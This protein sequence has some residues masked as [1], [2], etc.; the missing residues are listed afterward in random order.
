MP[1]IFVNYRTGDG[2]W[3]ASR[4]D[5]ALSD[6]FGSHEVFLAP[7]SIP[8]GSDFE[9]DI[10]SAV[11]S[12][13]VLLVVVGA[14]WLRKDTNGQRGLDDPADW[15]RREIAEAIK[16]RLIVVPILIDRTERLTHASLPPDIAA[17]TTAQFIRLDHRT[18]HRDL[19]DLATK[20]VKLAPGLA[21]PTDPP[22]PPVASGP[23]PDQP[24]LGG[25]EVHIGD[26]CYLLH[27]G[28][29]ETRPP[30][31]SWVARQAVAE[32]LEP[33]WE[34]VLLRQV[35]VLRRT[36]AAQRR[37]DS[38]LAE[39]EF[40]IGPDLPRVIAT[41]R[42]SDQ[43]TL[44]LN[45]PKGQTLREAYGPTDRPLDY[46]RVA[47]FLNVLRGLCRTLQALHQRGVGHRALSPDAVLISDNM[48]SLRDLGLATVDPEPD[49]GVAPYQAPE[50]LRTARDQHA[51]RIDVY[52]VA[53]IAY[54]VLTAHPPT[55]SSSPPLRGTD[56]RLP[57]LLDTVL[58]RALAPDPGYRLW[59]ADVLSALLDSVIQDMR[60]G[61]R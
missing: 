48:V 50:Q 32:Q 23:R 40:L 34:S 51:P 45:R 55:F 59:E 43:V 61:R 25:T 2:D 19:A 18:A 39:Q 31:Y 7:K 21:W 20:M 36:P 33:T 14:D 16:H 11:R 9:D 24:W 30:D 10:L 41:V 53:A 47:E 44:V 4:I 29:A 27:D 22:L 54:H 52:Q 3:A 37:R 49:E 28:V 42:E 17:I 6:R 56:A 57:S 58:A 12:S 8:P 26:A 5:G 46:F 38:L 60:I 13:T 1:T 15:V 35:R